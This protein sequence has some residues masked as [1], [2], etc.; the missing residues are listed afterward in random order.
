M[1]Q[2]IFEESG[3]KTPAWN[4][5][6]DRQRLEDLEEGAKP[7]LRFYEWSV[8]SVTYGYFINP[9]EFFDSEGVEK[10][11]LLLAKRPTGGGIIFHNYDLAFAI[12]VPHTH[13]FYTLNSL[14]SYARINQIILSA[15]NPRM[16]L[17]DSQ[18]ATR[19]GFCMTKP[20]K[21]DLIMEGKKVGGAAQRKTK[22]GLLHQGSICLKLPHKEWLQEVLKEG[23]EVFRKMEQTSFPLGSVD[24]E[25]IKEKL[26]NC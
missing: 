6:I 17:D 12:I 19:G 18:I 3:P 2:W 15:L 8:P 22:K 23:E 1:S 20:T 4:M 10:H 13:L 9:W 7:F 11:G 25:K 24:K 16:V 26:F 21:Y 5:E 14:E